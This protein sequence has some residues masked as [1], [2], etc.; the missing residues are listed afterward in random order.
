VHKGRYEPEPLFRDFLDSVR[1]HRED[2][3]DPHNYELSESFL[4]KYWFLISD[5]VLRDCNVWRRAREEP[6]LTYADLRPKDGTA[7]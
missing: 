4:R 3:L 6:E 7:P 2:I 1:I 5:E